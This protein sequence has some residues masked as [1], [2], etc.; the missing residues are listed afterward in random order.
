MRFKK[1]NMDII[2]EFDEGKWFIAPDPCRVSVNTPLFWFLRCRRSNMNRL[3]WIIY[4][5]SGTPF[6]FQGHRPAEFHFPVTTLNTHLG[7]A[8][9]KRVVSSSELKYFGID[10]KEIADH[11]GAAGP[12]IPS[13]PGTYKYGLRLEDAESGEPISDDDPQLI[14]VPY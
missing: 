1:E 8:V 13:E 10:P 4:F 14:I 2:V 12:F 11:A 5:N 7:T 3:R 9:I 6:N